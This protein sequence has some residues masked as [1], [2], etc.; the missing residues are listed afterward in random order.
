MANTAYSKYE[1]VLNTPDILMYTVNYAARPV[2]IDDKNVAADDSGR[3]IVPAGTFLGGIFESPNEPAVK[4]GVDSVKAVLTT[5]LTGTDNNVT[6]TARE[7]G[8]EGN[9]VSIAYIDPGS[10]K[11]KLAISVASNVIKVNLATNAAGKIITTALDVAEAINSDQIANDLVFAA[12]EGNGKG[13][14]TALAATNLAGGTDGATGTADG[15]LR[16]PV[17]VTYGTATGT[18][19]ISGFINMDM[20]PDVPTQ[21][22]KAAM[23]TIKF[24]RRD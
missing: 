5:A 7:L 19:I 8:T 14:V 10:N 20:L 17:D 13:I 6:F 2:V 22:I 1:Q 23:P 15:V 24:M 12:T 18:A 16:H 11:A 4:I 3:K 9:D 21:A